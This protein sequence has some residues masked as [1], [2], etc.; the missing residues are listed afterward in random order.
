MNYFG[1]A[2]LAVARE[3]NP[4]FVLGAMLPDLYSMMR[5]RGGSV[6]DPD[7]LLGIDFHLRTDALFHQTETFISLN[8]NALSALRERNVSRGPARACAHIGVEML[9]DAVLI[10][11]QE[12]LAGYLLALKVGA[13]SE[14]V[15]DPH[16]LSLQGQLKDL[17]QHLIVHREAV[18]G[19]DTRRFIERLGHTLSGR[20]RL[21]PSDR[22]LEVIAEYLSTNQ[23]VERRVPDLLQELQPLL[24]AAPTQIHT[25]SC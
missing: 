2:A 21:C 16:P 24:E 1:H 5:I 15:F 20:V 8:R 3:E 10:R 19:T 12:T 11:N 25:S 4:R 22:E 17:C 13:E 6:N 7:L 9:I 23:E 18:H 14:A